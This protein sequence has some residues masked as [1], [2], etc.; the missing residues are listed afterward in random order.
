MYVQSG[1][2]QTMTRLPS[3]LE[4]TPNYTS[5]AEKKREPL[6]TKA[7][8]IRALP[9]GLDATSAADYGEG[10]FIAGKTAGEDE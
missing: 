6:V 2:H 5:V 4:S 1:A 10:R 8:N 7:D 9:A 3:A